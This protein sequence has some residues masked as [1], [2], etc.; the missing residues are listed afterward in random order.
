M[1]KTETLGTQKY[2]VGRKHSV[3]GQKE[4]ISNPRIERSGRNF[5]FILYIVLF[6][7]NF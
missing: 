1:T 6:R 2:G 4:K 5:I 7:D 3:R